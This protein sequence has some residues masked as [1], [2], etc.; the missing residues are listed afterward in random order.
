MRA[1]VLSLYLLVTACKKPEAAESQNGAA[2]AAG[3]G[4]S[5]RR[6]VEAQT[7]DVLVLTG[8]VVPNWRAAV[9]ADT[10]GKVLNVLVERGDRVK[11]GQGVVSLDVRSAALSQ[12]EAQANV[13]EA[14]AQKALAE[15][16]C[17][18][19]QEL[20]DKGAITRS[21]YDRQSTQCATTSLQS[22]SRRAGA[23]RDDLEVGLRWLRQRAV[24]R[25]RRRAQR[26]AGRVGR[27]GARAVHA[28]R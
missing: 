8:T 22:V 17:K 10:A 6:A 15:Q 18:R 9:T 20:L 2:G 27:A 26:V 5:L 12:R 11:L 24:R 7:P 23:R 21:E 3:E 16:E 13:Q 28:R 4:R 19:A 14:Q 1:F 25:H